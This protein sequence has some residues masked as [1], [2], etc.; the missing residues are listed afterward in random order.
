MGVFSFF[1][2]I[3]L[4]LFILAVIGYVFLIFI[5]KMREKL[6]QGGFKREKK[7]TTTKDYEY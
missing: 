4:N 6:K 1:G 7:E 3:I 2:D 5:Q